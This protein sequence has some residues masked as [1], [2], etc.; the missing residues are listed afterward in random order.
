MGIRNTKQGERGGE[1]D[2]R[3]S[4]ALCAERNTRLAFRRK[5][6]RRAGGMITRPTRK[7]FAKITEIR[8]SKGER[9]KEIVVAHEGGG[10]N[11]YSP[12]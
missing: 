8:A 5:T 10:H 12:T 1:R 9:E 7:N 3:F 6:R 4:L 2:T 11:V